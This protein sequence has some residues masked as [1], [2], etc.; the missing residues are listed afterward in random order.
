MLGLLRGLQREEQTKGI[1]KQPFHDDITTLF[2]HLYDES[3]AV[4]ISLVIDEVA[5]Q[6]E[7]MTLGERQTET[8]T[9]GEIVDL[10]SYSLSFLTASQTISMPMATTNSNTKLIFNNGPHMLCLATTMATDQST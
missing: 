9:F 6:S 2:R 10:D 1:N 4:M 8:K 7:R 5:T 3:T